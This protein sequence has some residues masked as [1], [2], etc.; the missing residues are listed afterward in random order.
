MHMKLSYSLSAFIAIFMTSFVP[1]AHQQKVKDYLHVPGPV[2]FNKISYN[3]AWSSHPSAVYYKQEYIPAG[4][5]VEKFTKMILIEAVTG[6][7]MLQDLVKAKTGELDKRK[8]VD[9]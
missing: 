8:A 5:T 1:P 4:Q 9:N 6:E 3:L 7:F 2:V